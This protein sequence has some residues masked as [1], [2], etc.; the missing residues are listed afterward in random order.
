MGYVSNSNLVCYIAAKL[1]KM[2]KERGSDEEDE[3]DN[4]EVCKT[5]YS[6]MF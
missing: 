6:P 4:S 2:K 5:G 1:K 3:E